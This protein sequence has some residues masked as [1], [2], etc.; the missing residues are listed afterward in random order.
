MIH[1]L[2]EF[3]LGMSH[4]GER[5]HCS[6]GDTIMIPSYAKVPVNMWSDCSRDSLTDYFE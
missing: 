1:H 4:D 2:I 5:G 3:S 6:N